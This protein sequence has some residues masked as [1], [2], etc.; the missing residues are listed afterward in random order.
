MEGCSEYCLNCG[1]HGHLKSYCRR[2]LKDGMKTRLVARNSQG[3]IAQDARLAI[4]PLKDV[5]ESKISGEELARKYCSRCWI[6]NHT[7]TKCQWIKAAP[8]NE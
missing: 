1:I 2:A 5:N 6:N 7:T 4:T 8:Q 3:N